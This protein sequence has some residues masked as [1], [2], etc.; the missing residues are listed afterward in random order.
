MGYDET[1]RGLIT[2]P[3]PTLVSLVLALWLCA[4][5]ASAAAGPPTHSRKPALDIAG[6]NH[7][8]GVAVDSEGDVYAA[9]AGESKIAIFD[10]DH[11]PLT[12]I[13][14]ANQPCGLAV[15]TGGNLYVSEK[16]TGKVVRYKPNAYPFVGT[17]TYGAAEPIDESGD[18]EGI[19]IDPVDDR[20]YVAEGD[21]IAVY[22]SDGSFETNV[23]EGELGEATG[24]GAFSYT[25]VDVAGLRLYLFV[26]DAET[27]QVKVF[28]GEDPS[29]LIPRRTISGVDQDDNPET[30]DQA[31][32]FGAAG[33]YI[34][35]DP[36]NEDPGTRGCTQIAEQA[37]TAGHFFVYDSAHD[38]V[39]E[40]DASGEYV[41]Q[42]TNAAFADA[43]PTAVAVERSGTA[44]DGTVYVSAGASAG[45]TLV[46]FGPLVFP[47]RASLP[48]PISRAL[49]GARAVA[50]DT[51]GNVYVGAL[52]TVRVYDPEGVELTSFE[53]SENL[54]PRDLAVD[55][56][57]NVYVVDGAS[58]QVFSYYQ[59]A[60]YPPVSGTAY[61]RH[62]PPLLP[63]GSIDG[64]GMVGAAV[65]P[66]NDH[67]FVVGN[68]LFLPRIV[69]FGS[70]AE[71]SPL[72]SECGAGLTFFFGGNL[73]IDVYGTTGEVYVSV[74]PGKIFVL[75]CDVPQEIVRELKGGGCPHG[76]MGP[77]PRIAVD[78]SN[79]HVLEFAINQSGASAREYDAA[80]ACVSEFG[81][82]VAVSG[83]AYRVAVDNSCAIH[84]PPLTEAT[85]P[86]CKE[87]DPAAGNAY[88]A[89][90]STNPAQ[91]FD[92][93]A[94][95]PLSYGERPAAA[96]GMASGIG[97]GAATLNGTVDPRGFDLDA[98]AFEYLSDAEYTA[99]LD[100]E[101]PAF[102]GALSENCAES[103]G[104]IGHGT[105]PVPVHADLDGL[106]EGTRYRFRLTA[107]NLFG[108]SQGD[109][110]TFGPPLLSVKSALPILYTEA[111]LRA[112]VDPSGLSTTY[113]F[114]YGTD[115]SYG[116]STPTVE[117]PPGVG[118]VPVIAPLTGLDEGTEYHFRIVIENEAGTV[119]GPDQTFE[120]RTRSSAQL[121]D[122]TVYRTGLSASLPDCR[123]YELVTPAET[124][125]V[126][127]VA[128]T[129]GSGQPYGNSWFVTPRGAGAGDSVAYA[130]GALPGF[131][132][133]GQGDGF[134]ARRG[135]GAHPTSGW[136]S[137]L[138][139]FSFAQVGGSVPGRHG[140]SADQHYWLWDVLAVDT[141][142]EETFPLGNYLRTRPGEANPA[143]SPDPD[144]EFELVG[145]ALPDPDLKAEG[146]HLSPGGS[147]VIFSSTEQL[148]T[149]AAPPG[150]EAIYD[151]KA[152]GADA[153]VISIAPGGSSFG[154]GEDAI[155]FAATEDGSTVVFSVDGTL[156]LHREGATV[157]VAEE[158]NTFAGLSAD[159][160]RVFY[161]D[162]TFQFQSTS[163]PPADLFVCDVDAGP[164]VGGADP[165]GLTQIAAESIFVNV[166]ADG[167]RAFF[168]SE[169]ALTGPGEENENGE[170][171]EA[172]EHNLYAWDEAGIGFIAILDP[173]DLIGWGSETEEDLLQWTRASTGQGP[174]AGI[175]R[176]LSPTRSTP[177]GDV[178]VF[179]SHARLTS[180]DNE[181][182]GQIY[183]AG[184]GGGL[185]CVSCDPS[186]GPPSADALLQSFQPS[187]VTNPN[188]LIPNV[189]DD[190]ET[191]FFQSSDPLVPDDAN[192]VVDVYQ[193]RAQGSGACDLPEGCLALISSGQGEKP[194][195]L[196]GM[197][198]DGHDVFFVT[199]ERLVGADIPG[200]PSMYDARVGGGIPNPPAAEPCHGDACQS[201]G[202]G[203]PPL[204]SPTTTVPAPNGNVPPGKSKCPAGK[205]RVTKGGKTRC[206]KRQRSRSK[207]K[208]HT[209]GGRRAGHDRGAAR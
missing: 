26:A 70:V 148:E 167:S 83:G 112:G 135:E 117:L 93:S 31:F 207:K 73:D 77:T 40:F 168:T 191:V 89:Y 80:G 111:T 158:P 56:A 12:S 151:R 130:I 28:S 60:A 127:P 71:G 17:P 176:G 198:A 208:S 3:T 133:T 65:N 21:H 131:D 186:N 188:T 46:A 20:L 43:E 201:L 121:C 138:Y 155:Y 110:G 182:K 37:C 72:I 68:G 116:Q 33:A 136:T 38:V 9:S 120:T 165:A 146:R 50:T 16:A 164:C 79:G 88:V 142:T 194:S 192:S 75:D 27:D 118:S 150:T 97:A 95:G 185:E 32:G 11:D 54:G 7:A 189:S 115:D 200:S 204:A 62:E 173:Q 29:T 18:A 99:N 163:P 92:L 152:G 53:D 140:I 102:A 30:P 39:D 134:R 96:T 98:C 55:S 49:T 145:C 172:S 10:A 144:L 178:L 184:P 35:V 42:F 78:Q 101:D 153:E 137:E 174:G 90:D 59:P 195:Y 124:R 69:E 180:F 61:T 149:E 193:W 128:Q 179:Q 199:P 67:A 175:G 125:G 169:D 76:G 81:S 8:C 86:T 107:G 162:E 34:G 64:T 183:R 106:V 166:A 209:R 14:N 66:S 105:T 82:F 203:S 52:T 126:P 47:A 171:A 87:F 48:A 4:F 132:G 160:T 1:A 104:E 206:V 170:H 44:G 143:C 119:E 122:N 22:K 197:T 23:G 63:A 114:E 2:R 159:G 45:A 94:F 41:D 108:E 129:S 6:L 24:V 177:D 58:E 15:D 25:D 141:P 103:F 181:G 84:K 109:V 139:G 36:G 205:R 13:A 5:A 202:S 51:F 154:S 196:Y 190:G 187:G 113:R 123:A 100:A 161:M 57:G 19:A 147:H 91:A 156:Y 157:E 85:N 74:N